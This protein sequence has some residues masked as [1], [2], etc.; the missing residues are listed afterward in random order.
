MLLT[1]AQFAAMVGCTGGT[2]S[3]FETGKDFSESIIK[4]I[5]YTIKD[6]ETKL[7]EDELG[8]YKLRVATEMAIAEPD[9]ELRKEKLRTVCFSALK[10]TENIDLKKKGFN[11]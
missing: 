2:I 4:C 11:R 9:D 3:S 7:S 1:Q 8:T 10:W 5:K 6:L